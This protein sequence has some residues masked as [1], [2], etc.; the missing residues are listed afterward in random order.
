M[1]IEKDIITIEIIKSDYKNKSYSEV[2]SNLIWLLLATPVLF[3]LIF[4]TITI[5]HISIII[6]LSIYILAFSC[7]FVLFAKEFINRKNIYNKNF[8]IITDTLIDKEAEIVGTRLQVPKPN[9]LHFKISG[10]YSIP[11]C[12]NYFSAK[13]FAMRED[14]VFRSSK[15]G[16]EFYLVIDKNNKILMAYN[17]KF[18]EFQE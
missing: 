13:Q 5:R 18:F 10:K 6:F 1:P 15:I 17:T 2:K 14:E 16:D 9:I 4:A 11:A 12:M 8:K 7:G 3:M